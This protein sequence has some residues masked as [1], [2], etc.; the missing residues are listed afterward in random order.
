MVLRVVGI[1]SMY[2]RVVGIPS[3]YLR[4]VYMLPWSSGWY[5]PHGPQGGGYPHFRYKV[6]KCAHPEVHNGAHAGHDRMAGWVT[7]LR[8]GLSPYWFNGRLPCRYPIFH[9]VY[10]GERE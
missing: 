2:L 6:D 4:V 3:M 8:R 9:I 5:M 7:T 1:P 10:P